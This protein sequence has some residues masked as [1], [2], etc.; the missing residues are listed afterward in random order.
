MQRACF[1]VAHKNINKCKEFSGQPEPKEKKTQVFG[2]FASVCFNNLRYPAYCKK[3][4]SCPTNGFIN[5]F[6]QISLSIQPTL[7]ILR[8]FH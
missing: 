4:V 1:Q 8:Q 3:N 6:I 7:Q 5:H 2:A